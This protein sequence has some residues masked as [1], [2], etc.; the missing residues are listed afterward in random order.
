MAT[1][2]VQISPIAAR[3]AGC[4]ATCESYATGVTT[5][6]AWGGVKTWTNYQPY[7]AGDDLQSSGLL[8]PVTLY[9][10]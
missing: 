10:L 7:G 1:K 8:G 6:L 2:Q 5:G 9:M 4:T 3:L